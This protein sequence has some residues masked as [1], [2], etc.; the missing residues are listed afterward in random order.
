MLKKL[1]AILSVSAILTGCAATG[2]TTPE[3]PGS[4]EPVA[5]E[6]P[7][8]S[9]EEGNYAAD[10]SSINFENLDQYLGRDDVVYIDIRDYNDYA[11]KHFKNFEVLPYFALIWNEAAHE[12]ET[13]VQLF[14]GPVD[15]PVAVYTASEDILKSMFPEDKT[16]FLMCQSGGR[17]TMMMQILEA[18][19]YDMSKIYNVGGVGQYTDS[20]YDAFVTN[21]EEFVVEVNYSISGL[22]RN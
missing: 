6:L 8:P 21:T 2:T 20:K 19:G 15:A 4:E 17:V 9:E 18:H 13:M 1:I 11:K 10:A 16:I 12:D 22:T 7:A 3:E 5:V 14:G